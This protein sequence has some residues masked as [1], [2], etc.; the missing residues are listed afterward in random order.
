MAEM[1]P[2]H[3]LTGPKEEKGGGGGEGRG[4]AEGGGGG[5]G[6]EEEAEEEEESPQYFRIIHIL[7]NVMKVMDN[8]HKINVKLNPYPTIVENSVSS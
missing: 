1:H 6:E 4:E 7:Q 5:G 8:R 2:G 3:M